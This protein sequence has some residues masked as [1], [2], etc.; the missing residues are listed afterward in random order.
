[1]EPEIIEEIEPEIIE[2]VDGNGCIRIGPQL[3]KIK[4]RD[5]PQ[6]VWPRFCS[7]VNTLSQS[8][9]VHICFRDFQYLSSI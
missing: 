1:M 5:H 3:L 6:K 2:D 4:R 8:G 9:R 7:S